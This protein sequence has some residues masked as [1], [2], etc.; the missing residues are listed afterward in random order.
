MEQQRI[1]AQPVSKGDTMNMRLKDRVAIVTGAASGIGRATAHALAGEGASVVIGD[2]DHEGGEKV[3]EEIK[4]SGGR[5]LAVTADI[6]K[7]DEV[8]QMVQRA[9]DEFGRV[10][11]MVN[12][13][14]F[15]T[16][17]PKPFHETDLAEW[18]AEIDITLVGTLLC[19]KAVLPHMLKQKNGRIISVSS[20]AGKGGSSGFALYSGCKSAIAGFSR[21]LA[22]ELA[23]QGITVNCVSPGL[24]H[25][26]GLA[27]AMA[28]V[29]DAE[30]Q[31]LAL[32]PMGKMGEPEDVA[33]MI[34]FLA[35][36]GA[37]HITGQDYSVNGGGR[38]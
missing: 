28:K 21:T 10:D 13:A 12:N 29:P 37:K 20:D 36:D 3:A 8:K 35:S 24:I 19:C 25:T 6:S 33:S 2:M 38:M 26:P 31:W 18:K 34:V 11:I 16:L 5:A 30:S 15:V 1:L 23:T 4:K 17:S 22:H 7:E 32:V 14:G 27:M 9:I